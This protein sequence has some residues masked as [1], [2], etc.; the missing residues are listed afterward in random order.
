MDGS[1]LAWRAGSTEVYCTQPF[2]SLTAVYI[3]PLRQADLHLDIRCSR[4][5][6]VIDTADIDSAFSTDWP[7][8]HG[9]RSFCC[10][11]KDLRDGKNPKQAV[12]ERHVSGEETTADYEG[13]LTQL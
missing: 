10:K 5:S 2:S 12:F 3:D 1:M 7:D 4:N 9:C 13:I 8:S 6:C 11:S